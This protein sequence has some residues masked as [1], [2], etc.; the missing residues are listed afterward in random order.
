[1][2]AFINISLIVLLILI[3]FQDFKERQISWYLIPLTFIAFLV[4]AMN[5]GATDGLIQGTL[6]NVAFIALQ[7]LLLTIYMSIKN[8]KMVNIVNE[9][10]GLGD[11]L[12]FIV[13]CVA[14]SPINFIVFYLLSTFIT[15]ISFIAYRILSKKAT[16]EIPLAGAMASILIVLM[17]TGT[18]MPQ[19]NFYDD[20]H[21]ITIIKL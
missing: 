14:F 19:L 10:L 2:P 3:S 1:M 11:V 18:L 21:W 17:L 8:K 12:F 4:R 20:T 5:N 6:L 15:L 7:L 13:L 9:Y 16:V